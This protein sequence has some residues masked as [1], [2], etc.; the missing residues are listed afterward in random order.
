LCS[1]S[2]AVTIPEPNEFAKQEGYRPFPPRWEKWLS[3][4][5]AAILSAQPTDGRNVTTDEHIGKGTVINVRDTS[6]RRLGPPAPTGVGACCHVVDSSVVCTQETEADCD[7]L[8]GRYQGDGTTCEEVDCPTSCALTY[9]L[10]FSITGSAPT[11]SGGPNSVTGSL[12][13]CAS[14]LN[15]QHYMSTGGGVDVGSNN[16]R[17]TLTKNN[18][19]GPA[20]HYMLLMNVL[21][22]SGNGV[23]SPNDCDP[24][25]EDIGTDPRGTYTWSGDG[26]NE[27]C[28]QDGS[29][30][31]GT[32]VIS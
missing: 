3:A 14:F 20:N 7:S 11:C 1:L 30:Y 8:S 24:Q 18:G 27:V 5:R 25:F 6:V 26:D 13:F 29:H 12:D 32:L 17:F 9:T 4:I 15:I 10:S 31:S 21:F 28:G 23:W 16:F 22:C 2:A 19:D